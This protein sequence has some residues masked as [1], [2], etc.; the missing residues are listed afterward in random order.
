MEFRLE[1]ARIDTP[2]VK[3]WVRTGPR[4]DAWNWFVDAD[5][6]IG[7]VRLSGFDDETTLE[8]DRAI[9]QMRETGLNGLVFDLRFN[10]GGLLDQAV[11]IAQRF[12]PIDKQ[13]IVMARSAGGIEEV[14][15]YTDSKKATLAHLP[16]L[17]LVNEGSASASEI[18][19][20]AVSVFSKQKNLDAMVIGA[21]SFGKGSVQNVWPLNQQQNAMLKITTAYYMLPDKTIIHRRPG[22]TVW[23]VEPNLSVSMLP[24]QVEDSILIRRNADVIP[25]AEN[26]VDLNAKWKATDPNRVLTE[27]IDLQLE[28]AVVLLKARVA[29]KNDEAVAHNER[30]TDVSPQTP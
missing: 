27:G 15:G 25:L 24:Q 26:G 22:A 16:V 2:S 7:Y 19:S 29:A 30:V 11:S 28:S 21:R 23:G 17:I 4:E 18:V 6:K 13:P 1:R 9:A 8:L 12:L 20:G 10:P 3:G 5:S 14:V